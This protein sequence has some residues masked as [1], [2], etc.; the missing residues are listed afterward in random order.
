MSKLSKVKFT[1]KPSGHAVIPSDHSL[2]FT[3]LTLKKNGIL[4][5]KNPQQTNCKLISY[6]S[7]MVRLYYCS[8]FACVSKLS[9]RK[10]IWIVEVFECVCET[11]AW[12]CKKLCEYHGN[13]SLIV[14]ATCFFS[15]SRITAE[16]ASSIFMKLPCIWGFFLESRR[17]DIFSLNLWFYFLP[18]DS[19]RTLTELVQ[20]KFL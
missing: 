20:R 17:A 4:R 16:Y 13:I 9:W 2:S 14:R 10:N 19:R 6:A 5:K 8:Q 12:S 1:H 7:S 15:L 18:Y 11:L 3:Q